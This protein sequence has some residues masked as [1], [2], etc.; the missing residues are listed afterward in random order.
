M[1]SKVQESIWP[2]K[3]EESQE[4]YQKIEEEDDELTNDSVIPTDVSGELQV[5][6]NPI[7]LT[8]NDDEGNKDWKRSDIDEPRKNQRKWN[9]ES[10]FKSSCC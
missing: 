10:S 6:A 9:K 3:I 7:K 4:R 5:V 2:S 1:S 8:S